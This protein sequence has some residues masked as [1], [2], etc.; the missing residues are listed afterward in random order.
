M[1]RKVK[2]NENPH[3]GGNVKGGDPK[4]WFPELWTWL[5]NTFKVKNVLD[6]GCGQGHSMDYFANVLGCNVIG[7]DGLKVN[8]DLCHQPAI[9]ADLTKGPVD[10]ISGIDLV[11][12]CEVVEHVNDQHLDNLMRSL[13]VGR[14][15]AVTHAV[16]G[17]GGHHH[18]NEQPSEYWID[19]FW[20]H[21]HKMLRT[22]TQTSRLYA[23]PKS[24]WA[25]TGM[26]FQR[27]D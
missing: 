23:P 4:T 27:N 13:T 18:V 26:L 9:F 1:G 17:Q 8:T 19:A 22:E 2:D 14:V 16:P 10:N 7:V 11:W 5:V 21:G 15:V 12:C 25:K 6:L 24:Y 3:L 20:E